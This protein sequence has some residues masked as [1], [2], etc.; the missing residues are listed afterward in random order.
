M[1]AFALVIQWLHTVDVESRYF[2]C[3]SCQLHCLQ[4]YYLHCPPCL[5]SAGYY[6]GK[7]VVIT[8]ASRGVGKGLALRLSQLGAKCVVS[9]LMQSVYAA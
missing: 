7:R 8:G 2:I 1:L 5:N 3:I 4:P 9:F 6:R